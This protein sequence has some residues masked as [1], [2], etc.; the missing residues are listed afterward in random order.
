MPVRSDWRSSL[1]ACN[2][3]SHLFDG[4]RISMLGN[5]YP[6]LR[7]I[8]SYLQD[9]ISNLPDFIKANESV[10]HVLTKSHQ[11]KLPN[12]YVGAG[13]LVQTVWNIQSG[14]APDSGGVVP[15]SR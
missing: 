3:D 8:N 14:F 10:W 13:C 11:L 6:M 9:Q 2:V 12:W 5:H 4:Q 15:P 7:F 1:K